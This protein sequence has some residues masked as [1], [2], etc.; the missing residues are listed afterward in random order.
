MDTIMY[1]ESNTFWVSVY[2]WM[3]AA[4]GVSAVT[5]WYV[6]ANPVLFNLFVANP[7]ALILL[8]I[9]QLVMV[10]IFTTALPRLSFTTAFVS[11]FV[12]ALTLGITLSALFK[13]YVMSSLYTTFFVSAGM[14]ACMALYGLV[15]R[16]DLSK[17]GSIMIMMVFG[18]MIGLLV[19][20]FVKSTAFDTVLSLIGVVVF[21]LLTAYDMQKINQMRKA[22]LDSTLRSFVALSG[23]FTLYLDFI[24]LFLFMLRFTGKRSSNE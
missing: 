11:F 10:I 3:A 16:A 13:L 20:M 8:F 18:L 23:A 1:Q 24:N 2:G 5:A 17:L 9:V 7:I 19:N 4:L 21:S 22:V 15:T 12:Y 14:F 6:A